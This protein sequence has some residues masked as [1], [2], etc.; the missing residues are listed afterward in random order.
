MIIYSIPTKKL[1]IFKHHG[2]KHEK[3]KQ[4]QSKIGIGNCSDYAINSGNSFETIFKYAGS[5]RSTLLYF[6][7]N[8]HNSYYTKSIMA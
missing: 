1:E 2:G 4:Y 8:K 6:Y 3:I 7:Y 5:A